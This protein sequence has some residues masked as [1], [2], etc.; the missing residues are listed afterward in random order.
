SLLEY[1]RPERCESVAFS[2]Q[3]VVR[4]TAQLIDGRCAS[5]NV[6]IIVEV[7]TSPTQITG[8][9]A[10]IQQLL[11]NLTLNALDAMPDG[12][13][14]QLVA[15]EVD[16]SCEISVRDTG[17]GIEGSVESRLFTPFVTTKENGVGLGLGI[18]RRIAEQHR[19]TL[20]GAN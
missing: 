19:G 14:L 18:C 11:L 20:T 2:I 4:N 9:P 15:D 12:G 17:T 5:Q 3:E 8:D 7:P 10:Q 6:E 16:S 1:A 13:K